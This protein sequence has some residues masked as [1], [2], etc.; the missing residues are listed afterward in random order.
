MASIQSQ[1][2]GS[3]LDVNSLVTQLVA[4]DRAPRQAQITRRETDTTL[5]ISALGSLKGALGAFRSALEGLKTVDA[6]SPRSAVSGDDKILTASATT[7]AAT[8]SYQIE[9]VD[10]AKSQQLASA[11]YLAGATAVVGTGTLA[12]TQGDKVFSVVIDETNNTL[13]GI[14]SAIN[15]ATGNTGVQATLINEV[16]GSRLVLTSTT[17]GQAGAMKIAQSGGD[18]G[19]A[20]LVYDPQG[21]M[22]MTELAPA[23]QAHIRVGTFDVYSSSNTISDA[24]DGVTLNLKDTTEGDTVS[25]TISNDTAAATNKIKAFVNAYN[26][27]YTTFAKLRSYNAETKESGPMLG[28]ALLQGIEEGIRMDLVSPVSGVSGT[29][30]SLAALGITKQVDG[31]LKVDDTKLTA[32]MTADRAAVAAVFGSTN[33]VATRLYKRVDAALATNAGIDARN[34]RLQSSMK[35]INK[36]KTDLD[37]RMDAVEKRYRAQFGALDVLLSQMQQTSSYLSQQLANLPK[38]SG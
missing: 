33:G 26:T 22:A 8:G 17:T 37:A 15:A 20:A 9:V 2:I 27:L 19:L 25:V 31:T 6:L 3:G 21:T 38:A 30:T 24:I 35:D 1:G 18:G 32:A 36:A 16:G 34:T 5:Q 11:P 14:R 12:I 23:Q 29:Y 13:A 10:L 7:T 28:D 4:A